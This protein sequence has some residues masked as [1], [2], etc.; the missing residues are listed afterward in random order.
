MGA[1][2]LPDVVK[3]VVTSQL[4]LSQLFLLQYAV[5]DFSLSH[6]D[7]NSPKN[8]KSGWFSEKNPA[9]HLLWP[10]EHQVALSR[11]P[12]MMGG[13]LGVTPYSA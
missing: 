1:K 11:G 10:G 9:T 7:Q 8:T 13:C 2:Y 4:K 12:A 5:R 6:T 3:E